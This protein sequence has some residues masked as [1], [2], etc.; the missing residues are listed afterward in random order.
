[1][2]ARVWL[3][4]FH[5]LFIQKE[6]EKLKFQLCSGQKPTMLTMFMALTGQ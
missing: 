3:N 5:L 4:R 6:E 1:M 2:H